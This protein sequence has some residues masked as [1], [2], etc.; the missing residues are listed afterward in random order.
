MRLNLSRVGAINS[1]VVLNKHKTKNLTNYVYVGRGSNYGNPFEIGRH[2]TREEVI[3]KHRLWLEERIRREPEL[4]P[5]LIRDLRGKNLL[6]FCK[7]LA[8]HGDYLL[9]LANRPDPHPDV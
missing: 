3:E 7:P 5:Q 8:C 2:G 9:E 6:C 4:L 1:P